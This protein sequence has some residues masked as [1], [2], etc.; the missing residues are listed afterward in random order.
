MT[1]TAVSA[2]IDTATP[3]L[4]DALPIWELSLA[5]NPN[6]VALSNLHGGSDGGWY[7]DGTVLS[8]SADADVSNGSGSRYDFRN[9]TGDVTGSPSTDNPVSVTMD[10]ARSITANYQLQWVLTLAPT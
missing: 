1:V 5:T 6:S 8:L 3:S 7:D 10:Q 9:W 2:T 4:H